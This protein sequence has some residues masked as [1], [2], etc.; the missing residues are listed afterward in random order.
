MINP[1][2]KSAEHHEMTGYQ[3]ICPG[4]GRVVGSTEINIRALIARCEVCNRVFGITASQGSAAATKAPTKPGS[5]EHEIGP[6]GQISIKRSWREDFDYGPV[7]F[8]LLWTGFFVFLGCLSPTEDGSPLPS[9]IPWLA[10]VM[11]MG[12]IYLSVGR[13]VNSTVISVDQHSLVVHHGPMPWGGNRKLRSTDINQIELVYHTMMRAREVSMAIWA[14]ESNGRRIRL[15]DLKN[16]RE[17]EYIAW[18]LAD[19]LKCE[20]LR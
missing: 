3:I 11:G 9:W 17:A 6:V 15:L 19:A 4:C 16:Q 13:I 8:G 10:V 7:F 18:H 14:N 5:L 2:P 20:L 12:P 1:S